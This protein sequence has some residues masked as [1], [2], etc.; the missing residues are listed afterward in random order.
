MYLG[1]ESLFQDAANEREFGSLT[2]TMT[3]PEFEEL[4][5]KLRQMRKQAHKDNAI[6]RAASKGDRVY[7]LNIQLFPVTNSAQK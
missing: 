7:Q 2:L 6:R 5:F 4:K 3:K 1:L